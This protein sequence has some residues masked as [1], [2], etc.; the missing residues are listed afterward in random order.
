MKLFSNWL[1]DEEERQHAELVM[2]VPNSIRMRDL[3]WR[4]E[5]LVRFPTLPEKS[6]TFSNGSRFANG[7]S[8]VAGLISTLERANKL[9]L[10]DKLDKYASLYKT[11]LKL[12]SRGL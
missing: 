2:K 9:P 11:I 1:N 3:G 6:Y 5:F 7:G 4:T 8:V 12:K 10:E